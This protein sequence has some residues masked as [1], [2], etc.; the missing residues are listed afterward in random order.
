Q[1]GWL[2]DEQIFCQTEGEQTVTL[3]AIETIG[4]VKAVMIPVSETKVVVVESRRRL[5][6]DANLVKEGAL[7]YTVDT[8]IYSGEGALVVYPIL[9]ND[10]YRDQSPLTVG[11]SFT[12]DGVTITVLEATNESDTVQVTI[13]Q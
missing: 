10:P 8:S 6:Y 2:D 12:I 4:G 5:G 3:S 9:E 1:M 7:V 13:N 11:E